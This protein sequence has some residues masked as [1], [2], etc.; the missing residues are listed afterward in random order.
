MAAP[1]CL[2]QSEVAQSPTLPNA[3]SVIAQTMLTSQDSSGG[4]PPSQKRILWLIPTFDVTKAN[5]PYTPLTPRQKFRLFT[6]STFDRFTLVSAAIDAGINQ[7]TN[8]P[9]GYGQGGEGYAKRY[10]AAI[11][12]KA[13]SDFL[14]KFLFPVAF[15]QDPRY[16][17]LAEGGGGRRA[18]Y[19]ISRVFVT[20][21]DSGRNHFNASQVMGAFSS[22]AISN[23]WYPPADRDAETTIARG[24]TRL[25]VGMGVNLFKE[26][27]PEIRRKMKLGD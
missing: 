27:W 6:N 3:P 13:V 15:R 25:A 12:D 10:G 2:A 7:G 5:A 24:G 11:G 4:A 1:F 23:V 20:R 8:T 18:G 14:G 16:F 19:A 21:G 26:F 17:Q 22:A 9:E